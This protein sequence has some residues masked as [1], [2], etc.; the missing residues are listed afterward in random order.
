MTTYTIL[1]WE[2]IP[3]MIEATDG[4]S[5]KKIQLS[6]R[7]QDLVDKSAMRRGLAGT[8]AYLEGFNKGPSIETKG[9]AEEAVRL[10]EENLEDNFEEI[11]KTALQKREV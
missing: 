4:E 6:D 2:E 5:T 8:D 1:Y 9:S 3:T 7:F 11:S 10:I